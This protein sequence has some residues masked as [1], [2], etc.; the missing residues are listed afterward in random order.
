MPLS[1]STFFAVLLPVEK[2]NLLTNPSFE[3]GSAGWGT[4]QAGTI[5]TTAAFQAFGAWAGSVAPTSNGTTGALS[6][7]FTAGNGTDY[8][9][10]IYCRGAN[11]IPYRFGV[12]DSN[13]ASMVG[14]TTF[15]GGGTWHRYSFSWTEASGATRALAI[16]KD[17]SAD[18]SAF[19]LDG[20][21]V[22]VGSLTTY[23]DGDQDGCYW[24][25]DTHASQSTRS[26]TS[27]AGGSI[28]A[29]QDLGLRVDDAIGVGMPPLETLSQSFA[30]DPG[31]EFLNQRAS[32]RPFTLTAKPILGTTLA[33]FHRVR[34]NLINALKADGVD[35]ESPV[36]LW[37]TG[38]QGTVQIDAVLA[39]GFE[40]GERNGPMAEEA[41]IRFVAHDPYWYL[42]TQQ[43]TSFVG[44]GTIGSANFMAKRDMY[45]RW[46]T[47]GQTSGTTIQNV[48]NASFAD[49][50]GVV[51][52]TYNNGTV[53]FC[54]SFG[55]IAGTVY[56]E[57]GLYFEQA[58]LFGTL[59]GGTLGTSGAGRPARAVVFAPWGSLMI[60]GDFLKV[61]GTLSPGMGQWN[62]NGFG[63]LDGGKLDT[64]LNLGTSVRTM[65]F[66]GGTLFMGGRTTL[67][68]GSNSGSCFQWTN[69]NAFGTL[70]AGLVALLREITMGKDD[71]LYV[72]GDI[73]SAAGT[74]AN[75]IARW[76]GAWGTLGTGGYGLGASSTGVSIET[77]PDG[78][79]VWGGAFMNTDSGSV[80]HIASW[81]GI[82]NSGL[83]SGLFTSSNPT[84]TWVGALT[85][86]PITGDLYAGGRFN[87]AGGN[88]VP[89]G[90]ARW[91]SYA[92]LPMDVDFGGQ[93]TVNV[94]L[95]TPQR[96]LYAMGSYSGTAHCAQ[97]VQVVN[98]GMAPSYPTI[99][100]RA[101]S[102]ASRIYQ[103]VNTYPSG[104]GIYFRYQMQ[105]GEELT[106]VTEPGNRSFTSNYFG[107]V[108]SAIVPGSNLAEFSLRPGTN[109]LSFFA[110][111]FT[112]TAAVYWTPRSDSFDAGTN[113]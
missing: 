66:R 59:Q 93:G 71:K 20:A 6:P 54:G 76:D 48:P 21:M 10:S 81:N 85:A 88:A 47:L 84:N 78:R 67:I 33:D 68:A 74:T 52:A 35:P 22:E 5:G 82:S 106:L 3:K 99:K 101:P 70:G 27:R 65:I 56:N 19:Y 11:G 77:M 87:T 42:T 61:G 29:L 89:D 86:D 83:G 57:I 28:V 14:S 36:R 64:S 58:N 75:N 34:R 90:F 103:F 46:G 51:D 2:T 60:G 12:G 113:Y 49:A 92:W 55:S 95:L 26:G 16:K 37:Y 45:G 25:G 13:G 108:F 4:V 109:F 105:V 104:M 107:N 40:A 94:V 1:G 100:F 96:T 39:G 69:Q 8:T 110:D 53:A 7:T 44:R 111:T 23:A 73:T 43:G 15:T 41:A 80:N 24:L 32:E 72:V 9:A 38:G 18:T 17:A 63:T 50:A 102:A 91:N 30:L 97:V 98:I 62:V 31:S 112:A 79:I